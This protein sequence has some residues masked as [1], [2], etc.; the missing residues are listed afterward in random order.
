MLAA[1]C[2]VGELHRRLGSPHTQTRTLGCRA[3]DIYRV[4]DLLAKRGWHL[5]ALQAPP[6]LHICFT[7]AHTGEG[8]AARLLQDLHGACDAMRASPGAAE[9]GGMAP[10]YGAAAVMPDRSVVARFL[11]AYQDLLLDTC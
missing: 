8:T 9:E 1:G 10:M 11:T 6:A 4:N 7:A 5:N 3:L 2:A